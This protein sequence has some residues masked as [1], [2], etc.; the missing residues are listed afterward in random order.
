MNDG[1]APDSMTVGKM[2]EGYIALRDKKSEVKKAQD[3]VLKQ[4][5]DAMDTIEEFLGK[6]L[7]SLN[8]QNISTNEGT[9]FFKTSRKATVSDKS[10]FRDYIISS[11]NFDM[12]DFSARVEAVEAHLR[13]PANEGHLP[14]GVNFQTY[15]SVGVQRK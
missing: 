1:E 3:A 9:A 12:A 5:S 4:Y 15:Q 13:D 11:A 10:A 14:P 8:L 6:H 7:R 2:I